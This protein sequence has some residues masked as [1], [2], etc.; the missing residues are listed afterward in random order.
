[1]L[2]IQTIRERTDDA[3]H[4]AERRTWRR[5]TRSDTDDRRRALIQVERGASATTL[6]AHRRGE[7]AGGARTTDRRSAPSLAK[8]DRL[9][10]DLRGPRWRA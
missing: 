4:A 3:T 1:V 5:S 8:L 9:E 6:A 10:A 2:S 7:V